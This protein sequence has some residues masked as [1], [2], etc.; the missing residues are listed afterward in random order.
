MSATRPPVERRLTAFMDDPDPAD[1][2][3][4]IHSSDA[5]QE[6]DYA[7]ALVV[8]VTAYGWTVPAIREA[9]GDGW[10]EEGW[11]DVSFRRPIY[12]GEDLSVRLT[13]AEEGQ[14]ELEV[15]KA[16]GSRA[17]V[18]RVGLGRAAWLS[19][20]ERPDAALPRPVAVDRP[21]LTPAN[22]PVGQDVPPMA[23]AIS[24]EAAGEYAA[25]VQADEGPPWGGVG[26]RLHPGWL[27]GRATRLIEHSYEHY[28]ALHARSQIQ[29]FGP[30]LAGQT[31]TVSGRI[32]EGYARKGHEYLVLDC[33]IVGEDGRDVAVQRHTSIYQP[34]VR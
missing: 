2:T 7:A 8:G 25:R 34:A 29:H 30:A 9:L 13:A 5:A 10:L 3:N 18:G 15:V 20:L 21:R 22:L 24:A 33:W 27:A 32:V 28:P 23:V 17:L 19:D 1:M 26:A 4:A 16:D 14:Q 11:I 12:P 6:Y 31:L